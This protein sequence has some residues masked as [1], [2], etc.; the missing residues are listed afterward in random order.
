ET[1]IIYDMQNTRDGSLYIAAGP[2]ATLLIRKGEKIEQLFKL[3]KEQIFCLDL[4][5]DGSLLV[6]VSGEKSRLAILQKDNTLKTLVDLP[7]TR[8]I[9]DIKLKDNNAYLATG[10]EG[11]LLK[12]DLSKADKP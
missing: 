5:S 10:T 12:V 1:T 2:Q 8:Y 3:D 4:T 11:K 6:G 9:W 7:D